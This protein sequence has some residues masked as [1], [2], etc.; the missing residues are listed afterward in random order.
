MAVGGI[1]EFIKSNS[2]RFVRRESANDPQTDFNRL[3]GDFEY[4]N[5]LFIPYSQKVQQ[6]DDLW[7]Q[8]RTNYNQFTFNLIDSDGNETALTHSVIPS[9]A[10]EFSYYQI[11]ID[12]TSLEG[13]YK[14]T[15]VADQDSGKVINNWDSNWFEIK[16]VHDY[17]LL[18]EWGGNNAYDDGMIWADKTQ[19]LRIEAQFLT[20]LS[21]TENTT[22]RDSDS[23][24]ALLNYKPLYKKLLEVYKM[25]FD[26]AHL[27]NRAVGHD[28]F[29]INGL[30]FK[31]N[32]GFDFGDRLGNTQMYFPSIELEL[33]DYENYNKVI[34]LEGEFPIVAATTIKASTGVSVMASL[35]IGIRAS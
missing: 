8:I 12:V 35:G 18:L 6:S 7:F 1:F 32:T 23:N 16:T 31:A 5:K 10:T 25:P 27:L 21:S 9:S 22:M 20:D 24:I 19:E 26:I 29:V 2:L 11:D 34:E 17:T 13:C 4:K 28:V 14:V 30:R 15:S 33:V 3:Y